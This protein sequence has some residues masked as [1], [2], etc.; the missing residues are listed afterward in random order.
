MLRKKITY[1]NVAA[2]IALVL[3]MSGGAYAATHVIIKSLSQISPSVQKKLKAPGAAGKEGKEG[4]AGG[5]GKEGKAGGEGKEGKE[6]KSGAGVTTETASNAEC[7]T[8]GVKVV[9]ASGSSHVCNGEKGSAGPEGNIK[10][11]LPVGKSETGTWAASG[12]GQ[13]YSGLAFGAHLV[14]ASIS[15]NVPLETAPA[16]G[17]EPEV[18]RP[19]TPE[20]DYPA[21]CAG[22]LSK[23]N[24]KAEPG[25]L[26]VFVKS[27]KNVL[28]NNPG[29]EEFGYWLYDPETGE[30]EAAGKTGAAMAVAAENPAE[31]VFAMGVW[32]VTA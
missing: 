17:G 21:G 18:I 27:E 11:T 1:A 4:K 29:E 8:G 9:S 13:V 20:M 15:F 28:T 26:C 7:S 30:N 23:G 19:G 2:T 22:E 31:P 24:I 25:H 10:A 32:V 14:T 12:V 6:G 5:E 16:V 3:A